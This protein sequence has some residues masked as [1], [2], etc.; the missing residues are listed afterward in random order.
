MVANMHDKRDTT[1]ILPV[2][3]IFFDAVGTL[4]HPTPN[5]L[6]IYAEVGQRFGSRI[7]AAE[8]ARRF[9]HFFQIE[10]DA[11]L[12]ANL[13][14]S[15]TRERLRW[16]T[17]VGGVLDDVA[18]VETCFT[19]LFEHFSRPEAWR[20]D[21]TTEAVLSELARRGYQLGLASNYDGRLRPVAAGLP[22][23]RFIQHLMISAE[24]GW[25]KP[26]R[27]FFAAVCQQVNL[28]PEAILFVGDD[29]GNDYLGA[30]A[31]G[32][33]ALLLDPSGKYASL[34]AKRLTGL[35]ELIAL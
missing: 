21:P 30:H 24:V 8:V 1:S 26:S 29:P 34:E 12:R 10:E 35:E 5:A 15:E 33:H 6:E 20:C 2:Q 31:H 11:D 25:R 22:P 3:A 18:D 9:R 4:I 23:L 19:V 14:T 27:E 17:I 13:A 28:P 32:L 16:R 7:H